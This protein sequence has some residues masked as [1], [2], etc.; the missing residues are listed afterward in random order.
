MV[1]YL[2]KQLG[3]IT[4]IA[5]LFSLNIFLSPSALADEKVLR[6]AQI[7]G[8]G[9]VVRQATG[10]VRREGS[11]RAVAAGDK[12][13]TG[14][15]LIT[16]PGGR[17]VLERRKD[18][19]TM[20][21]NSDLKVADSKG[22]SLFTNIVQSLGTLLFQVEKNAQQRFQ[23][24][25]PYLAATVKG[26][27]FTVSVRPEGAAV[28]VTD[29]AVQVASRGGQRAVIVLPGQTGA[30]SSKPGAKVEIRK[31]EGKRKT[32]AAKK[33]ESDTAKAAKTGKAP[34]KGLARAVGTGPAN[35]AKL[36]K[37]FAG[38]A[39]SSGK[40]NAG[41]SGGKGKA[42]IDAGSISPT[43]ANV[44]GGGGKG[45]SNGNGFGRDNVSRPSVTSIVSRPSGIS[46]A[47]NGNSRGNTINSGNSSNA[48]GNGN[49][50]GSNSVA[51]SNGSANSNAGGNGNS[52]GNSNAGG[53]GNGNSGGNGNGN[54]KKK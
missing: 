48:G 7:A 4:A 9:W 6:V 42:G 25:T 30:V 52:S 32:P 16:G 5:I 31:R 33:T 45:N 49:G 53:N 51:T 12:V 10:P 17:A 20:S 11:D 39:N 1:P 34:G 28:H 2:L 27:T 22:D 23:V 36:T 13:A 24:A 47:S 35:F 18:K 38:N 21:P 40:S 37:G 29:G 54:G 44:A 8:D 41:K 19:I 3:G 43:S 46:G 26:T 15:R 50:G 14:E